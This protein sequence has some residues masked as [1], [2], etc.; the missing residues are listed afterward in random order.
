[1]LTKPGVCA[2]TYVEVIKIFRNCTSVFSLGGLSVPDDLQRGVLGDLEARGHRVLLVAVH[3]PH[4]HTPRVGELQHHLVG[5][6]VEDRLQHVAETAPL[7]VEV[8][9]HQLIGGWKP[10]KQTLK[11]NSIKIIILKWQY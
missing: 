10:S 3:L 2:K 7:R 1:M 9:E 4:H 6:L 11:S 5:R 8:Y